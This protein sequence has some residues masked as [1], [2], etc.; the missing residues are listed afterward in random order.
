LIAVEDQDL[1]IED[2]SVSII[3]IEDNSD[4]RAKS[5]TKI[6][7]ARHV[8]DASLTKGLFCD[9]PQKKQST[10]KFKY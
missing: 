7:F 6:R 4:K 9:S 1:K 5:A 2:E 10:T 3:R 8:F